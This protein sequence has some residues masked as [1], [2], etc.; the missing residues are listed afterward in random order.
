MVKFGNPQEA[1]QPHLQSSLEQEWVKSNSWEGFQEASSWDLK[2]V[3][4]TDGLM[5]YGYSG[6]NHPTLLT[7]SVSVLIYL[8]L[9]IKK[10]TQGTRLDA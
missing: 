2:T 5:P 1:C 10:P 7:A 4:G 3:R 6:P 9:T 8:A